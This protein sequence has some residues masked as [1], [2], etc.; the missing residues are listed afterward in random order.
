MTTNVKKS[1]LTC[2]ACGSA[3]AEVMPENACVHFY[4]CS[5]CGNSLRPREGDCCVFCSYESVECPP[6]QREHAESKQ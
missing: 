2:P 3:H 4:E 1:I 6:K 5:S